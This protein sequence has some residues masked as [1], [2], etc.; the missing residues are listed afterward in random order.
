MGYHG[1]YFFTGQ[2]LNR[3]E[4]SMLIKYKIFPKRHIFVQNGLKAIPMVY[5]SARQTRL[6]FKI[7]IWCH[8]PPISMTVGHCNSNFVGKCDKIV[9]NCFFRVFRVIRF[10]LYVAKILSIYPSIL[11]N[12]NYGYF[13]GL[14]IDYRTFCMKN[15]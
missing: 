5:N 10:C 12:F 15:I 7:L 13:H 1:F 14:F 6:I 11:N 3:G 2:S 4:N 8:I 9:Y